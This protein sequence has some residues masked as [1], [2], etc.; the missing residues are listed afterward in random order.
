MFERVREKMANGTQEP[1]FV[2]HLIENEKEF[3]L[4]KM[5]AYLCVPHLSLASAC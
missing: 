5:E 4:N 2:T 1:C 3:G